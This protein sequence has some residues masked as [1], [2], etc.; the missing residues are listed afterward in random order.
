MSWSVVC[1]DCGDSVE[2]TYVDALEWGGRHRHRNPGHELE[3]R[4]KE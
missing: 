2:D 3:S 1:L 4:R